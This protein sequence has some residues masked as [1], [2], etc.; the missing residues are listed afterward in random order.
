MYFLDFM[1]NKI[2]KLL[3]SID[4]NTSMVV[5]WYDSLHTCKFCNLFKY[6]PC[7]IIMRNKHKIN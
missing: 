2:R 5:K 3:Q 1:S 4:I 6:E 7:L